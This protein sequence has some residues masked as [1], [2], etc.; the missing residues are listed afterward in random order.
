[1]KSIH[2]ILSGN[3]MVAF[4]SQLTGM[5]WKSLAELMNRTE[6]DIKAMDDLGNCYLDSDASDM[7]RLIYDTCRDFQTNDRANV[8]INR[9]SSAWQE[10]KMA[11]HRGAQ[12]GSLRQ[13][14][15]LGRQQRSLTDISDL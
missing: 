13:G 11:V 14:L 4:R 8:M 9:S 12:T 10:I 15:R 3:D 2:D 6:D 1:M 5:D 7:L